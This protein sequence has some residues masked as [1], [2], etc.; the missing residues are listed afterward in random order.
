MSTQTLQASTGNM[1]EHNYM[2]MWFEFVNEFQ[3]ISLHFSKKEIIFM[4]IC[5]TN[6]I[7]KNG[8]ILYYNYKKIWG[9]F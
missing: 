5:T 2:C 3:L 1:E 7:F 4:R 6:F 9:F 8:W